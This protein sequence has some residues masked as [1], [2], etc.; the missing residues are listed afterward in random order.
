MHLSANQRILE[1]I[2]V[3]AVSNAGTKNLARHNQYFGVRAA[4]DHVRRREGGIVWHTQGSGK[5]LTMVWLAKWVRE[6]VTDARVL[7]VTDRTELDE[8]IRERV[9]LP[10]G[11]D[12]RRTTSGA[13]LIAVLNA[14]T[15]WLVCSLVHK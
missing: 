9:F 10:A 12:I 7:V 1:P 15:P 8:Q 6:N 14:T 2:H 13:D 5:S 4:Q 3:F 11:E